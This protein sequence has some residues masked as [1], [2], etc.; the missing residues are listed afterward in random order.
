MS[1]I[2][3][4]L[5]RAQQEKVQK[6]QHGSEP[7]PNESTPRVDEA[8]EGSPVAG[9]TVGV[10]DAE[11][12]SGILTLEVLEARCPPSTWSPAPGSMLFA[13]PHDNTPGTEEFRSLRSRLY[14][15]REKRPLQTL[16][17]SSAIAGEGKTFVAANLARAVVQQRGRRVLLIDSDLRVSRMCTL[18]GASAAPG[19]SD[20][21]L[22]EADMFSILQHGP[23][24][25][26][27]FIAGG[28]RVHNPVELIGCGRLKPLIQRLAPVFDWIILDSPPS[29]PV[30]DASL[31]A[32]LSDGVL[33]V[34]RAGE[35]PYDI[36]RKGCQPFVDKQ[37]LGVILNRVAPESSYRAYYY[38]SP[39]GN[40]TKSTK[41][42]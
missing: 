33:M 38:Y 30:T 20:Y 34:V 26:L 41:L 18:L 40:D 31:L 4:A 15:I 10:I 16:L 1:R 12:G 29:V 22:G 14:Q 9:P 19:L 8:L 5:I 7:L 23:Q 11:E 6:P 42:G 37:L 24:E 25:G 3:E 27:F 39:E 13:D 35:T 2:H 36:A 32:D 21:L 28:K 17:V